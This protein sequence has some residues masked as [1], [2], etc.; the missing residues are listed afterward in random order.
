MDDGQVGGLRESLTVVSHPHWLFAH[1]T[2]YSSWNMAS[3]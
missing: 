3:L 1:N 2:M